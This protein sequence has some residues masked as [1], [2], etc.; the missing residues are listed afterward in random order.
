MTRT[1]ESK[2]ATRTAVPLMIGLY[3]PSGGGKTMSALRLA[4][5][6]RSVTGGD[7]H[8]IDTESHRATHYADDFKFVHTH[9]AAPFCPLDYLDAVEHCKKQG[10]KVIIID[11]ASHMHEGPGGMLEQHDEEMKRLAK[12]WH[13]SE[14]ATQFAAWAEPKA[15][16]QRFTNSLLQVGVSTIL[17]FRS[18]E[19]TKPNPDKSSREKLLD[20]GWMPIASDSLVYEMTVNFLLPPSSNGVPVFD[21]SNELGEGK[22]LKLP[23]QFRGIVTGR[24][25]LSESI[26][27]AMANW[28]AG[29][30]LH[31]PA[32]VS[33]TKQTKP[34]GDVEDAMVR[35]QNAPPDEVDAIA[36]ELRELYSWN[37]G[38][39]SRIK[40]ALERLRMPNRQPQRE[41]GQEG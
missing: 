14:N 36:Q 39:A 31:E 34:Q 40:A 37:G 32:S 23:K 24:E 35:L 6:I 26:G 20:L 9:F 18:K 16:V 1:F 4:T 41:P 10:A 5:G 28:A 17:C 33:K 8:V 15:K 29:K 25:P 13:T 27:E 3:G 12:A 19:K 11:S 30:T 2:P 22:I 7:I 38:D 21:S